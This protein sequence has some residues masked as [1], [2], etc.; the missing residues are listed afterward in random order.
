MKYSLRFCCRPNRVG[1]DKKATCELH[2]T[3]DK[4]IKYLTLPLRIEPAK[5]EK[6]RNDRRDN[7]VK[8]LI[9]VFTSKVQA[10]VSD[11]LQSGEEI[12][13]E[14]IALAVEGKSKPVYSIKAFLYDWLEIEK[15]KI[16]H[17]ITVETFKRY[18][19]VV[20]FFIEHHRDPMLDISELNNMDIVNFMAEY[21]K[22]LE[23]ATLGKYGAILKAAILF[24]MANG[25][26]TKDPFYGVKLHRKAKDREIITPDDYRR[27]KEKVFVSSKLA[28]VRDFFVFAASCGLAYADIVSLEDEKIIK[29]EDGQYYITG[30]R[31]KT[32]V[33]YC[34]VILP[35][36]IE[37]LNRYGGIAPLIT[38]SRGTKISNQKLNDYLK[39]VGD[40]CECSVPLTCH[41]ARHYYITNLLRQGVPVEVVKVCAGHAN[42]KMT[43]HYT[44]LNNTD[45]L[46]S[47][48]RHIS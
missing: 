38:S 7:E 4:K 37:V 6:M 16:D 19:R 31:Q 8:E 47:V 3:V 24:A 17:G 14:G 27:L 21:G 13:A 36:G 2:I 29:S 40:I 5:F 35:D 15:K 43:M 9:T 26:I 45:I 33:D 20:D 11:M 39:E 1:K 25:Y 30:Q 22:I 34:S 41:I 12:T 46:N 23:P 10:A 32:G 44:H 28:R 48:R 42:I 18:K